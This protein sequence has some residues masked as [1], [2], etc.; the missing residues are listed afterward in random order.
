MWATQDSYCRDD[1]KIH[2]EFQAVQ[3]RLFHQIHQRLK[4]KKK[5]KI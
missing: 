3:S 1:E 2:L 4:K 5:G